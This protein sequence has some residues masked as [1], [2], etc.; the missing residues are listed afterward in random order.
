ML[1]FWR[2][3]QIDAFKWLLLLLG[4]A[5]RVQVLSSLPSVT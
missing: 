5:T 3:N 2:E 4:G 1:Q